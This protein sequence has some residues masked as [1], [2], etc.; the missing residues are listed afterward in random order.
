MIK[1]TSLEQ[2]EAMFSA[3]HQVHHKLLAF[4]LTPKDLATLGAARM[5]ASIT[6]VEALLRMAVLSGNIPYLFLVVSASGFA[7]EES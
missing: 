1:K 2:V 6:S 5:S 7:N 3:A 4:P